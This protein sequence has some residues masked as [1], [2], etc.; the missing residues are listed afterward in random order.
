MK[1]PVFQTVPCGSAMG[2]DCG[3]AFSR[4]AIRALCGMAHAYEHKY[5]CLLESWADRLLFLSLFLLGFSAY[6][7]LAS[8]KDDSSR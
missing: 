5:V 2:S 6:M 8:S 7:G 4:A 1:V 3:A